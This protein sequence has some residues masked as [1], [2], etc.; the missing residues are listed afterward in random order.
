MNKRTS[1][2]NRFITLKRV[3]GAALILLVAS[4]TLAAYA[5]VHRAAQLASNTMQSLKQQCISFNR[6]VAADRTKS[7]YRLSDM[8]LILSEDL[9]RAP[10]LATDDYLEAY[11]D[12]LRLSGVALLNENGILEASGYTRQF[13]EVDWKNSPVGSQFADIA[14]YPKKIYTERVEVDGEYYDVCALAREDAPGILLGFYQQPSGLITGMEGD[15]ESLLSWSAAA[16]ISL[17]KTA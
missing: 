11:V 12:N 13:R 2:R 7:L 6:L 16:I 17:P 9:K 3:L 8:M 5:E 10:S 15:L 1:R 4:G 14:T